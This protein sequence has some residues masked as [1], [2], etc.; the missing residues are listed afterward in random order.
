MTILLSSSSSSSFVSLSIVLNFFCKLFFEIKKGNF[1]YVNSCR[2]WNHSN[3]EWHE[4]SWTSRQF[5]CIGAFRT[6]HL[7]GDWSG[8]CESTWPHIV[9]HTNSRSSVWRAK[10]I[11]VAPGLSFA[12]LSRNQ[13]DSVSRGIGHARKNA[14]HHKRLCLIYVCILK[15]RVFNFVNEDQM[16][17]A[18]IF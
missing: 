2:W 9:W 1:L 15:M 7:L 5:H 17:V 12:R 14:R 16:L 4:E 6:G 13:W 11:D 18:R 3:C 10:S 8:L